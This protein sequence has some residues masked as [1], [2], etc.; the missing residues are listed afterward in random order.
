[1]PVANQKLLFKGQLKDEQTLQVGDKPGVWVGWQACGWVGRQTLAGGSSLVPQ[2]R[3]LQ[4]LTGAVNAPRAAWL[5]ATPLLLQEAGLKSGSKV[6]V[7]GSR[8]EEIKAS[9]CFG[10]CRS[11]H[12]LQP[13]LKSLRGAALLRGLQLDV[14]G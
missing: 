6:I 9:C 7:M 13:G 11:R 2:Q 12:R 5:L 14:A 4:P 1:V 10:C 3:Q 8:P